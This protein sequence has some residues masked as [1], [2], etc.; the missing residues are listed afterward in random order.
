MRVIYIVVKFGDKLRAMGVIKRNDAELTQYLKG[1]EYIRQIWA[2]IIT[3]YRNGSQ[4]RIRSDEGLTLETSA[5]PF[6]FMVV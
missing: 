4:I 2:Q 1:I 5:L 6:Y 3:N